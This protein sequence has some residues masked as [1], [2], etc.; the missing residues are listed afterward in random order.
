MSLAGTAWPALAGTEP[1]TVGVLFVVHGGSAEQGVADTFDSTLQFFQYDPNNIIFKSLIW[2][3]AAWPTVLKSGDS[4][5]YANAASQLKKYLFGTD[6]QFAS[7]QRALEVEGREL[8]VCFIADIAQWIGTQEQANRLPWPSISWP[9]A[10]GRCG[11]PRM[12][13][14]G[15]VHCSPIRSA[16]FSK[17]NF[18]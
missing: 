9:G 6:R 17:G 16:S 10:P 2:N 11:G 7:L 15:W 18:S 5:S 13:T 8:N 14:R 3:A 1:R 12:T 4:Q